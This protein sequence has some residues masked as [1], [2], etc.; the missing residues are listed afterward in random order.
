MKY[1]LLLIGLCSLGSGC[2]IVKYSTRNL[3]QAPCD[4]WQNAVDCVRNRQLANEA[5]SEYQ[6]ATSQQTYSA[7]F[8]A[9]FK[10]GFMDFLDAGG[11]GAPPA[12]PPWRFR[13]AMYEGI[14]GIRAV[15]DWFRGFREGASAAHASGLRSQILV[16]LSL[17]AVGHV[18]TQSYQD[19]HIPD[20]QP[21]AEPLPA[22]KKVT[23]PVKNGQ[24]TPS[25][26][27]PRAKTSTERTR[28]ITG[29]EPKTTP[30]EFAA[31]RWKRVSSTVP[32]QP[33]SFEPPPAPA[34]PS[35]DSA[36]G[37]RSRSEV[38]P[39]YKHD[40][41]PP[42]PAL[43]GNAPKTAVTGPIRPASH[44]G[45]SAFQKVLPEK[46]LP[47]AEMNRPRVVDRFW[48]EGAAR[49]LVSGSERPMPNAPADVPAPEPLLQLPK[50]LKPQAKSDDPSQAS[51]PPF[52]PRR[53]TK[54]IRKNYHRCS[55]WLFW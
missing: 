40:G 33:V 27:P 47:Q 43:S 12:A 14:E 7:H 26:D 17:S 30:A 28:A 31:D 46:V 37:A 1:S 49:L 48:P 42:L 2:G 3:V 9:G 25:D 51:K 8:E 54:T 23:P 5:W 44:E 16:P 13:K 11:T 52:S 18:T 10:E 45:T 38:P 35:Q 34:L 20:T 21:A 15:E 6:S 41:L 29:K 36:V 19:A 22:P 32:P 55:K 24:P 53:D 4:V 39:Q 50:Q